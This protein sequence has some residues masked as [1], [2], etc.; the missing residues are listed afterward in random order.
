MEDLGEVCLDWRTPDIMTPRQISL[1]DD[2]IPPCIASKSDEKRLSTIVFITVRRCLI[3]DVDSHCVPGDVHP[4]VCKLFQEKKG[5]GS[6][7]VLTAVV[8]GETAAI[9]DAKGLTPS[10]ACCPS[11]LVD[12]ERMCRKVFHQGCELRG[13]DGHSVLKEKSIGQLVRRCLK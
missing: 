2:K 11:V 9:D 1:V 12:G 5:F 6:P 13:R 8:R 7:P 3:V 10:R 4:F